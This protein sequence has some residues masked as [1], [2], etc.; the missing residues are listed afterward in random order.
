[1][2]GSPSVS[3]SGPAMVGADGNGH[4]LNSV[5]D[6]A[7]VFVMDCDA[8][9]APT[10]GVGTCE[11][12]GSWS[13][14]PTCNSGNGVR[15]ESC[16]AGTLTAATC[17]AISTGGNRLVLDSALALLI[18]A[19]LMP[20]KTTYR[21]VNVNHSS[22]NMT[23]PIGYHIE[24]SLNDLVS[25]FTTHSQRYITSSQ[26]LSTAPIR[27]HRRHRSLVKPVIGRDYHYKERFESEASGFPGYSYVVSGCPD[28][29]VV[30]NG[31]EFGTVV[32]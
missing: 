27:A 11:F 12:I 9:S 7:Y 4:T 17:D 8:S 14:Q 18:G 32:R 13:R 30:N 24:P 5:D 28:V 22:R 1:M 26:P 6:G 2:T 19:T 21:A 15:D 10:N 20:T 3:I 16:T 25:F 23:A 31:G 29:S